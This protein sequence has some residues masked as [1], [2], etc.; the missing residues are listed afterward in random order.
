[1]T[2][3]IFWVSL[4]L[5]FLCIDTNASNSGVSLSGLIIRDTEN[6]LSV[7]D[8]SGNR[9]SV[10]AGDTITRSALDKLMTNDYIICTGIYHGDQ[11]Y[12]NS[13][14]SVGIQ[15]LLGKWISQVN[16]TYDFFSFSQLTLTPNNNSLSDREPRSFTYRITPSDNGQW[17]ILFMNG[18]NV[19]VGNISYE[20]NI[21]DL[22]TIDIHYTLRRGETPIEI[23][24]KSL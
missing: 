24:L 8:V 20:K 15:R 13:I 10:K 6:S 17:S 23:K 9:I 3:K 12:I 14:Q 19:Q 16:D 1:M 2:A 22:F 18:H 21:K 4:L 11:F 5:L 7:S